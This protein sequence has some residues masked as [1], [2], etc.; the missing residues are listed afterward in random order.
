MVGRYHRH[1]IPPWAASSRR[2]CYYGD[3]LMRRRILC[4]PRRP[5]LDDG[6][7]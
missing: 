7:T 1:S 3:N 2:A 6:L 5:Y 4:R